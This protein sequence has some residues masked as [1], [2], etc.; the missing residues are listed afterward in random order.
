M[1]KN[2]FL[3]CGT[4][5]GEGLDHFIPLFNMD[6]S[7]IIKTFEANPITFE[8]NKNNQKYNYVE[9][10]NMAVS[11]RDGI[12]ELNLETSDNSFC[13]SPEASQGSSIIPISEWN[14]WKESLNNDNTRKH[15]YKKVSVNCFDL[16]KYIKDNFALTDNLII[17]MDIEGAEYQVLQKMINDNT[18]D[19]VTEIFIEFHSN[20][21][22]NLNVV[23][24]LEMQ[25]IKILDERK[26]KFNQWH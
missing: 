1:K 3:D 11:D 2:I 25:I 16:S 24:N 22:E 6:E 15:F 18:I 14:P 10:V 23:K 13:S 8:H 5:V 9:Y 4:F 7:W 19:Y 26:V 17:K 12:V 21:F 20:Y